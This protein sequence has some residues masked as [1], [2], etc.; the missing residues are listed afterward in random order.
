MSFLHLMSV[1]LEAR[2]LSARAA[3]I[4]RKAARNRGELPYRRFC[5]CKPCLR[6]WTLRGTILAAAVAVTAVQLAV[7][8]QHGV[9]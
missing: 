4:N 5:T 9:I 8:I 2:K 7:F 3:R 1:E 6:M